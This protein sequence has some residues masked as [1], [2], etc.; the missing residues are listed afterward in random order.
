MAMQKG[1]GCH[2]CMSETSGVVPMLV[3]LTLFQVFQDGCWQQPRNIWQSSAKEVQRW[4]SPLRASRGQFSLHHLPADPAV[5]GQPAPPH[6]W[7]HL[8]LKGTEK[9]WM[10]LVPHAERM[11]QPRICFYLDYFAV[12]S[13][14]RSGRNTVN[15][16]NAPLWSVF[17]IKSLRVNLPR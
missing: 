6:L 17:S 7:I 14:K 16:C 1:E 4:R 2:S 11:I 12:I 5:L 10:N 3:N 15:I 9:I 13:Y 8:G